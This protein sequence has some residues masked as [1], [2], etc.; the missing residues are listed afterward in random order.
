MLKI[1]PAALWPLAEA[2]ATASREARMNTKVVGHA[3]ALILLLAP[4]GLADTI[5]RIRKRKSWLR[6][7]IERMERS[8]FTGRACLSAAVAILILAGAAH[9]G[10]IQIFNTGVNGSG[11]PLTDGTVGDPHYTLIVVPGGTTDIRVL[12]SAGGYPVVGNWI[13]DNSISAWIGPNNDSDADG[14]DVSYTYRTTFDLSG[15]DPLTASLT[16][17]W[18]ADNWGP[19]ILLNGVPTGNTAGGF[20]SWSSFTIS[21]GFVLGVNALDFIVN[22]GGGPTGLRVE[23][24]GNATE[25]QSGVPEPASLLLLGAGLA[26]FGMFRRR[27]A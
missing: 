20:N 13:G 22:N 9:A 17:Q 14:P 19:N 11:A 23:V 10:P 1:R 2:A 8:I 5:T 24:T 26:A 15:F 16:G 6:G 12:T 4:A 27:L 7:G 21:S 3:I 25:V 18:S